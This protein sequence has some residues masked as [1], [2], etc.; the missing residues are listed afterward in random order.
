MSVP[1]VEQNT[2]ASFDVLRDVLLSEERDRIGQMEVRLNDPKI[3]AAELADVMND[4]MLLASKDA[5]FAR[6]LAPTVEKSLFESVRANPEGLA[7]VL[8]PVLMPAIRRIVST[9]IERSFENLNRVLEVSVSPRS[10][11]WRLESLRTGKPFGEI[12]LFHTISYRVEQVLLIHRET[13]LLLAQVG[14]SVNAEADLVSAM[15]TAIQDFARD[16][17]QMA[18]ENIRTFRIGNLTVLVETSPH[19]TLAAAVRGSPPPSLTDT[20]AV[21]LETVEMRFGTAL[22]GFQGDTLSFED[23]KP[24]LEMCLSVEY[25]GQAAPKTKATPNPMARLI[26]PVLLLLFLALGLWFGWSMYQNLRW[27]AAVQKLRQ[28]PGILIIEDSASRVVGLRDP[29]AKDPQSILVSQGYSS[30]PQVWGEYLSFDPSLILA[31]AKKAIEPA[32]S[33]IVELQGQTLV[34]K[35]QATEAWLKRVKLIARGLS[36]ISGVDSRALELVEAEQK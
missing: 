2:G 28:E 7:D 25:A 9:L 32:S 31:R 19:G 1:T 8:F 14:V 13:G 6:V 5:R 16:S 35:G 12:V 17:F 33:T 23:T 3:R 22:N 15:L 20:M 34:F 29:F 11:A 36:G 4:A 30:I 26:S 21:A 10:F 24:I 27:N 18:D